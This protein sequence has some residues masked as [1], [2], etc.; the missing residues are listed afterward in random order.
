MTRYQPREP[1]NLFV[2]T[3]QIGRNFVHH[4]DV[5]LYYDSRGRGGMLN[6]MKLCVTSNY[7]VKHEIKFPFCIFYSAEFSA[8]GGDICHIQRHGRDRRLT[9]E[10]NTGHRFDI[11]RHRGGGYHLNTGGFWYRE[12]ERI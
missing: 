4:N 8:Q 1:T 12:G 10:T 7:Q 11:T 5:T 6:P 2:E 3:V 9:I